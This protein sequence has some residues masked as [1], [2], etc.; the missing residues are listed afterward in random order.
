MVKRFLMAFVA[1]VGLIVPGAFA[2]ALL[3]APPAKPAPSH[4]A[5]YTR[6]LADADVRSAEAGLPAVAFSDV[7]TPSS[8]RSM[9][10]SRSP[11]TSALRQ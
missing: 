11:A 1:F 6:D 3:A 7:S 2:A 4:P 9:S 10:A 5:S 8:R